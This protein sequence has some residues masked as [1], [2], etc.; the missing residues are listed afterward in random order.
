[1]TPEKCPGCGAKL[2]PDMLACP[3]CPMSFPEDDGPSVGVVNPLKQSRYYKFVFPTV[4]LSVIGGGVWYMGAGLMHLGQENAKSDG[5][6]VMD[7]ITKGAPAKKNGVLITGDN[8]SGGSAPGE[9][10]PGV[11]APGGV[12][13]LRRGRAP[14]RP[15]VRPIRKLTDDAG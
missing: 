3:N 11:G 8:S 10:A 12:A 14:A 13:R 7:Q 1:M 9:P 4:L 2:R 5:I 15:E 6:N